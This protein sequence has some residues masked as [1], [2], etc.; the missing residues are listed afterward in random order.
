MPGWVMS[1]I[2]DVPAARGSA[3]VWIFRVLLVAGAAFMV[4]SWYAPWWSATLAVIPGEN[5]LVMRPWGVEVVPE[6]AANADE[7][8]YSM[9]WF[10][11]PFMWTY[12]AV[13][14][15]ALAASMF[16]DRTL[17]LGRIRLP[18]A[19]VLI[20]LV[21]LSYMSALGI[22]YGVGELKASM[23]GSNF[24]GKSTIRHAM[25]GTKVKMVSDLQIG[26]W[27]AVGAGGALFV[28]ALLRGLLI[29]KPRA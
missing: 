19:V 13:C 24:I 11:A 28:L 2:V 15:L 27:L 14:M 7:S 26:Y 5:H 6:V 25:T 23:A 29:R 22:A 3:R 9:P 18:L 1:Q 16:V 17:S 4:Y 20:A 8:L 10:F 12:L 21:G